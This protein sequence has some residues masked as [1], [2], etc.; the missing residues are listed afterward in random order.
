MKKIKILLVLLLALLVMPFAV[1]AEGE[2]ENV[3]EETTEEVKEEASKEVPL[4][5]FRGQG[6]SHCAEFEEWLDQIEEEYGSFYEVKDYETWYNQDNAALMTQVATLRH[7]EDTATGVPYIIIGNKSWIGFAEEYKDE[8]IEQIKTVYAQD[9]AE[10]YDI[11]KY[12]ESGTTPK[13][14][15][16]KGSVVG[17]ILVTVLLIAVVGG[18]GFGIYMAREK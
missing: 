1:F 7:E 4:Y 15:K 17:D 12:V 6:C 10:R 5:F 18:V 3:S 14:E 16:K 2:E 8:I 9:T 13:E 11:M